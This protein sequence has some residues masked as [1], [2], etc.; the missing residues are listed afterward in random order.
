MTSGRSIGLDT[1]IVRS[2][3]LVQS[4]VDEEITMMHVE[5]GKYYGITKVG[6][7]IWR[8]LDTPVCIDE[9]CN[10]LTARYKIDRGR[11]QE[12]VLAFVERLIAEE[13]ATTGS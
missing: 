1:V 11:C 6:A 2:A 7:D 13:L 8:M 3:D 10:R 12:E 4:E 5:S 9:V